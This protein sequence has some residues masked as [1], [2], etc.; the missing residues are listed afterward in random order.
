VSTAEAKA[1]LS[2]L[3]GAVAYGHD[4][5]VIERRGRPVA[6]LVSVDDA[7]RLQATDAEARRP[8]GALALVGAWADVDDDVL[9]GIVADIYDSRARD[10]GRL[11]DLAP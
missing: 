1:R 2:E 9:D 8:R 5:V 10:T 4:R 7:D 3:I 6:V 11:V